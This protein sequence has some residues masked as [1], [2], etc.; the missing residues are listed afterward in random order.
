MDFFTE[1]C[2]STWLPNYQR[3][4][5]VEWSPWRYCKLYLFCCLVDQRIAS[6]NR[7]MK[8]EVKYCKIPI[9]IP[10]FYLFKTSLLGLFSGE[11]ISEGF[12]I[13]GKFAFQNGLGLQKIKTAQN[14][15]N[16]LKQLTLTVHGLIFGLFFFGLFR[17]CLNCDSLRWSHT[18]FICIPAVHI[19][20]FC[21]RIFASEIWSLIFGGGLLLFGG[22]GLGGL[23]S[24][25]Y[26]KSFDF[27]AL[28]VLKQFIYK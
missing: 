16:S 10:S 17:N 26:G 25:F 6:C 2:P 22:G 19:I 12:I 14:N 7:E 4:C 13:G 3:V 23:L 24:E 15:K 8:F 20:S 27:V 28:V 11:I 21:G 18:H 1:I 5:L 9:I